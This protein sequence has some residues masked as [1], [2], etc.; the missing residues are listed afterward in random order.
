MMD[1]S[2]SIKPVT[3]QLTADDC[4]A[5]P[6][7]I[8]ITKVTGNEGNAAQPVNIH[9]EGDNGKPYRPAKIMRRVLVSV[10][11]PDT[12][13][14][15]GQ[16]ITLFRDPEVRFGGIACGG[17]RIS[18][19]TG[20]DKVHVLALTM[21]KGNKKPFQVKPLVL[22]EPPRQD[23]KPADTPKPADPYANYAREFARKLDNEPW[24][25]VDSWWT[26]TEE[27]REGMEAARIERMSAALAAKIE[28]E[29][30]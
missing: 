20:I 10:Y 12:S 2:E 27:Q 28:K 14:Y 6:V 19:V 7:T 21:S 5:G 18:H 4:L 9:F 26:D 29:N 8:K 24:Q 1:M 22:S 16:S 11:G 3:D 25:A 23:T 30:K 13:K 17:L 15:I